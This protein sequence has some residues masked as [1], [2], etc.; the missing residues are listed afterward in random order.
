M[1]DDLFVHGYDDMAI[2][3]PTYLTD[4]YKNGFNNTER[5]YAMKKAIPIA[6]FS[7]APSI[8]ATAR[9]GLEHLHAVRKSTSSRASSSTPPNGAGTPRATS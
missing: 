9:Q 7:T 2:L 4:F 1:Y 8:R 6:S 3:Q 5:N